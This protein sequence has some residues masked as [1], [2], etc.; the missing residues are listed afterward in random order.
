L[1]K[2]RIRHP[3]SIFIF[4]AKFLGNSTYFFN[5]NNLL[6]ME[7]QYLDQGVNK[8]EEGLSSQDMGYLLTAGKWAKFLGIMGFI[9]TAFIVLVAFSMFAM[10]SSLEGLSGGLY[11]SGFSAGLGLFYIV[12]AIPYF[13]ISLFLF[14]FGTRT[15]EMQYEST[16]AMSLT[17]AFKNLKNYFQYS[18]IL[19][20][21]MIVFFILMLVVGIGAA[22]AFNR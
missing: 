22:A 12:L 13:M 17:E 14:R 5:L 2:I 4:L 9:G 6:K 10:G 16:A 11:G 7:N 19:V 18:G 3:L 20:V 21:I 1:K 8:G 15:Q